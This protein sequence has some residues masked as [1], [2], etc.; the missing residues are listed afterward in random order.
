MPRAYDFDCELQQYE[1]CDK[2]YTSPPV[3]SS[4][5][6]PL[7]VGCQ[8]RAD[9]RDPAVGLLHYRRDDALL[10]AVIQHFDGARS[11]LLAEGTFKTALLVTACYIAN[12]LCR[13]G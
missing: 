7:P 10:L 6:Q 1:D 12:C 8:Q 2:P 13:T 3:E 11:R 5:R 4:R 9:S